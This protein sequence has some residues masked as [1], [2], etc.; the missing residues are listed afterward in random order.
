MSKHKRTRKQSGR[1]LDTQK[2]K[3]GL[4]DLEPQKNPKGG[5]ATLI[6]PY[7]SVDPGDGLGDEGSSTSTTRWLGSRAISSQKAS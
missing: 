6:V 7:F 2:D 4:N 1:K 5:A 3:V